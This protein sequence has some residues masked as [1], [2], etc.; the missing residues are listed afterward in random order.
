MTRSSAPEVDDLLIDID[1]ADCRVDD[2]RRLDRY[3]LEH[4]FTLAPKSQLLLLVRRSNDAGA[5]GGKT[6]AKV[7]AVQKLPRKLIY[8]HEYY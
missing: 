3:V 1:A 5:V 6:A 2:V 7:D 4:I 8:G